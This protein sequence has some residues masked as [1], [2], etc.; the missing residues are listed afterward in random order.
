V[1]YDA[2]RTFSKGNTYIP[3]A[4]I[5]QQFQ[6]VRGGVRF[7][8]KIVKTE[9][10]RGRL[11][12]AFA[13]GLAGNTFTYAQSEYVY[14]EIVDIS[15]TSE[16]EVCCP[17]LL[18]YPW[19][20]NSANIGKLMVFVENT[21]VA[22]TSVTNS[23]AILVECSAMSDMEFAT[24]LAWQVEPYLPSTSQMADAYITTPCIDLGPSSSVSLGTLA[25]NTVGEVVV[26]ARQ[27]LKPA[28]LMRTVTGTSFNIGSTAVGT[29]IAAYGYTPV[30]QA[31]TTGGVINRDFFFSD[32][33]NLW[34]GCYT[35]ST[36][37]IRMTLVPSASTSAN[38]LASAATWGAG[39]STAYA[40]GVAGIDRNAHSVSNVGV[41]GVL[42]YQMPVW[43]ST[44]A[45]AIPSQILA[46][47]PAVA[48]TEPATNTTSLYLQ[49]NEAD[50]RY[51][52][53]RQAGDD[54]HLALFVGVPPVVLMTTA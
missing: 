17:Y 32:Q 40:T 1:R 39:F 10:Q 36:G 51:T 21:L 24:P 46:F 11:L 53:F 27:L 33:I 34:M 44:F 16:F 22:P 35:Y 23:V 29:K 48:Q 28:N 2:G 3:Y 30:T 14:R 5:A 18:P 45:R 20:S 50:V 41:E 25:A 52:V 49:S 9:F 47:T 4:F 26:S 54:F 19:V 13:P 38:M 12:V 37:S 42:E 15:T 7:R 43:N 31:A 8:F 6:K